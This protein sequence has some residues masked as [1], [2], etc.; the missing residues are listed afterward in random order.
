[1]DA[2]RKTYVAPTV[3]TLGTVAALTQARAA[4]SLREG[5]GRS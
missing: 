1:M 3:K 2:K 4:F 5:F